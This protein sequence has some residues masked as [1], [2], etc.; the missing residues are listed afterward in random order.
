[1]RFNGDG[2]T[3][4]ATGRLVEDSSKEKESQVQRHWGG[5]GLSGTERDR[6][7]S[8]HEQ[9]RADDRISGEAPAIGFPGPS[10]FTS[11]AA[12]AQERWVSPPRMAP[13]TVPPLTARPGDF[14]LSYWNVENTVSATL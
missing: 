7:H 13:C 1:M 4:A 2:G 9:E 10:P 5:D 14:L 6:Q 12:L 8:S 11:P 3:E